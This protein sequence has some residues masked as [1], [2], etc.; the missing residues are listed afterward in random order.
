M[1]VLKIEINSIVEEVKVWVVV[2]VDMTVREGG[3]VEVKVVMKMDNGSSG[4]WNS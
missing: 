2:K 3:R 4:G 1:D